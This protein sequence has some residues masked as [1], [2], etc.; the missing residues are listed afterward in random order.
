M[1]WKT[2]AIMSVALLAAVTLAFG[3]SETN[4]SDFTYAN[5]PPDELVRNL[6]SSRV[7][8][9][10]KA[11]PGSAPVTGVNV[12]YTD[13]HT[14]SW[15]TCSGK[16]N[17]E[18]SRVLFEAPHDGLY[19][20]F[21]VLHN[22]YGFSELPPQ[23]G[24]APHQW[25]YVDRVNPDVQ[26][27]ELRLDEDFMDNREV[28]IRWRASDERFSDRPV[29]MHFRS[30]Q[31]KSYQL[32]SENLDSEGSFRWTV[33]EEITG[34]LSVKV[35]A[36]DQ[37]GNE[38]RSVVDSLS[39][40]EFGGHSPDL[41][42]ARS[43]SDRPG[44]F[45]SESVRIRNPRDARPESTGPN[46]SAESNHQD[47]PVSNATSKLVASIY[48][49]PPAQSP[50]IGTEASTEAEKRYDQGTWH[51]VRGE[52]D[53]AMVRFREALK[54]DPNLVGARND[55]AGLL[56]LRGQH[57]AAEQEFKRVLTVD[58]RHVPALKSLALVQ[59]TSRN[60][61]SALESLN[62]LLLIDE[63]DAE[64]WLYLGDVTMFRGD[65]LAA[66][67]FWARSRDLKTASDETVKRASRRLAIYRGDRLVVGR[68]AEP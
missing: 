66:R 52:Y 29:R 36:V 60:Y 32:I 34:R 59:A 28:H 50:T 27:V 38:G 19:G 7:V 17:P 4:P 41:A 54:H 2:T 20:F 22:A 55:L 3:E 21:I 37:A 23:P 47:R 24:S 31:T 58:P 68:S 61:Q 25:V 65:R 11:A 5:D 51:R 62:K 64:A 15:N 49:E 39:I 13:D 18:K 30:E 48:R 67:E 42:A 35:S 44:D 14:R 40:D 46:H 56:F 33:P 53:L 63:T 12:W 45:E 43:D 16:L 26:I 9:S 10:F 1:H 6:S 8:L 57:E